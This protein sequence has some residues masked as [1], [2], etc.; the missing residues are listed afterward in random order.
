M[1]LAAMMLGGIMGP[2]DGS[3]VNVVLPTIAGFFEVEIATAQWVTMVY[4]LAISSLLLFY[5]RLGDIWG[6]KKIYLSGLGGFVIASALCGLSPSINWLIIFRVLQGL[7]AG[8]MMSVPYA[9]IV[10][11]FPDA[12]R[13]RA[14]GINAI[15]VALGLAIGPSLGGFITAHLGWRFVFYIN[16]PIGIAAV[17]WGSRVIPEEKGEPGKLDIPGAALAFFALLSL[18]LAVNRLHKWD[19]FSIGC[20]GIFAL[21]AV[22]FIFREKNTNQ[23]MLRLSLFSNRLFSLANLAAL[24][25]FMSQ[26]VLVFLTP[27]YLQRAL[28]YPSDKVGLVMTSFPLVVLAVAPFAGSL[29]DRIGSRFLSCAGAAICALSLVLLSQL[30]TAGSY[31]VTALSV[32][33]RLGLFGLGTGMFQSP[34]NSVVM[35]NAPKPYLGTASGILATMRNVGMVLGVATAGAVLYSFVPAEVLAQPYLD[36]SQVALFMSGLRYAYIA[37]AVLTGIASIASVIR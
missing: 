34:N 31:Q 17:I 8:M 23:P 28:D 32:A 22:G 33:W 13:G 18:L 26:Y 24:L 27:F 7:A 11:A 12:E 1:V 14:L 2:L 21:C 10:R 19:T 4:L 9:I 30:L 15:M 29:S 37:G 36:A 6:Y 25:N 16:V 3:I 35:G 20:A 5:G